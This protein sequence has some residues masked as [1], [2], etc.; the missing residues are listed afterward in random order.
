MNDFFKKYISIEMKIFDESS[1]IITCAEDICRYF[2]NVI[3]VD[4]N[5]QEC[6][7]VLYLDTR[8]NII[9]HHVNSIGAINYSLVD[10]RILFSVG[11]KC[12]A[13]NMICIHNHPS[14][15]LKPSEADLNLFKKIKK[16]G[17]MIQ[18]QCLDFLIVNDNDSYSCHLN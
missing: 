7:I 11:L 2:R 10:L 12:L 18:I 6:F 3:P 9:A 5:T 16:F 13:T 1:N 14:G 8:N 17:D 4:I 15:N